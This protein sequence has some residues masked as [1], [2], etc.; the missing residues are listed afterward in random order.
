MP[1]KRCYVNQLIVLIVFSAMF[2]FVSLNLEKNINDINH[3]KSLFP[4]LLYTNTLSEANDVLYFV[5]SSEF[6]FSH[7]IINPDSLERFLIEKYNLTNYQE[8]AGDYRL[9]YQLELYLMPLD[10]DRMIY[11]VRSINA[12]FPNYIIQYNEKLWSDIDFHLSHLRR[13]L[14]IIQAVLLISFLIVQGFVRFWFIVKNKQ[15]MSAILNSGITAK[16][17]SVKE[18]V[19]NAVYVII[20]VFAIVSINVGINYLVADKVSIDTQYVLKL[21]SICVLSVFLQKPLFQK[22]KND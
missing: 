22:K 4:V 17:L 13:S 20:S 10:A 5:K 18:T 6:Y 1:I 9:P 21:V 15:V 11:F 2:I 19:T 16:A 12:F 8:I 3:E 14:L 7:V